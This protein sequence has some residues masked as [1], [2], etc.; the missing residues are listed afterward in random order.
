[1]A[2][3]QVRGAA[4][5]VGPACIASHSAHDVAWD[6]AAVGDDRLIGDRVI[7]FEVHTQLTASARSAR[8]G[9][10]WYSAPGRFNS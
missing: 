1:M 10:S 3:F 8:G 4:G 2:N 7:A 6:A 5:G 9:C